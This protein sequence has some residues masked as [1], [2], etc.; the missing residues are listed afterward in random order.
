M[1]FALSALWLDATLLQ[2][3]AQ[4]ALDPGGKGRI[5]ILAHLIFQLG[6]EFMCKAYLVLVSFYLFS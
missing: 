1:A 5:T 4:Y 6:A 2:F 3:L